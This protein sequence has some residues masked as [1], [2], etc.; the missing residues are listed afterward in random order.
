MDRCMHVRKGSMRHGLLHEIE[1]QGPLRQRVASRVGRRLV[2]E[3]IAGDSGRGVAWPWT[4]TAF[5][6]SCMRAMAWERLT[7]CPQ[8][9]LMARSWRAHAGGLVSSLGRPSR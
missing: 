1:R 7:G 3:P 6:G 8:T 2:S 9:T 5:G 4:G